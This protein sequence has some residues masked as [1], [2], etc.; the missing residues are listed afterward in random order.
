MFSIVPNP[1]FVTTVRLS[2]PGQETG[3]PIKV[4]WRHKGARALSAWL[5]SAAERS[6]DAS[7]LGEVI[8]DW[9]GVNGADGAA[10]PCTADNLAALLDA[11]PSAG[12]E[13]VRHYRSELADAR[14]KN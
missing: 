11:Y 2:V 9:Q 6:D 3:A 14:A 1:T 10:L 4:T 7:F 13:L 12:P 8:A 5:A